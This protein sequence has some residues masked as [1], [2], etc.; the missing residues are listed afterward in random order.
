MR[1]SILVP[2]WS[3]DEIFL[4]AFARSMGSY[5]EPSGPLYVAA[6]LRR[7]GHP[8]AF[9]DGA[10]RSHEEIVY[11]TAGWRPGFVG[12]YACAPLWPSTKRLARALRRAVP[13]ATLAVGGPWAAAVPRQCLAEC[14]ELDVVFTCEGEEASVDL[15]RVIEG[16]GDLAAV[17][18]IVFRDGTGG[19]VDTGYRPPIED[20]DRLPFPA[21]DLLG[22]DIRLCSLPPG[23]YRAR[24][25]AHLIGSRGCTNRCVYCYHLEREAVIR[26]RS[27]EDV[28]AEVE[29]CVHRW[30]FR[31]IR[32]LD[33]NFTADRERVFRICDLLERRGIE[34]PWYVSSRV[35][36]VDGEMLRR[37]KRAGCWAMLYGIESGV[38]EHLDTLGKGVTLDQVREVVEETRRAG[39]EMFLPFMFGIPGETFEDGL[40]TIEFALELDPYYANFNSLAPF[41]GT[42]LWDNAEQHGTLC[43]DPARLTFQGCAFVPHSMTEEEIARLRQLAFRRFYTRPRF[44]A[45]W[46]RGMSNRHV[47]EAVA[48]GSASFLSLWLRED[49]FRTGG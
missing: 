49:A 44:M 23:G 36:T 9:A 34:V 14:P 22:D 42:W 5:Q 20:L 21:R 12:L 2:P 24:P 10:L 25:V 43:A 3:V 8:V 45:R 46:L 27:A 4:S 29:E 1:C 18:G 40:R 33:D 32:F 41:P 48:R 26:F 17:P 6:A 13:G 16:G 38:Q 15:L 37:M 39:I 30:G 47:V 35:D 31:E 19:L 11:R 7:A 28:V